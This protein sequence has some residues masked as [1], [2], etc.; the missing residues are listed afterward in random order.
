[1]V[2][3]FYREFYLGPRLLATNVG[4]SKDHGYQE[5]PCTGS[6]PIIAQTSFPSVERFTIF[7]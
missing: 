2:G 4:D 5:K 3:S 6:G 7:D 1:M